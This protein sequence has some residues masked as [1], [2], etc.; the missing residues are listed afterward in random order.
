MDLKTRDTTCTCPIPVWV[1]NYLSLLRSL[2]FPTFSSP[3]SLP[4]EANVDELCPAWHSEDPHN[5]SR[6]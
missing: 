5:N 3:R 4:E 6:T 1:E 2:S